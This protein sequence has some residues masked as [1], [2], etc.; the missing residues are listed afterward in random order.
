MSSSQQPALP[1]TGQ[2]SIGDLKSWTTYHAYVK[3]KLALCERIVK[4][5]S[6][7]MVGRFMVTGRTRE[8]AEKELVRCLMS[9]E[10]PLQAKKAA[11]T[12]NGPGR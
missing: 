12:R 7:I 6:S 4:G 11:D 2:E 8:E 9:A 10:S 3:E 5:L 1:E